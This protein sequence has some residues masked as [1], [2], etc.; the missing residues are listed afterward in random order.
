MIINYLADD[1]CL[2]FPASILF[3]FFFSFM[4]ATWQCVQLSMYLLAGTLFIW[5]PGSCLLSDSVSSQVSKISW[6]MGSFFSV[7]DRNP[8]IQLQGK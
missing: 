1:V 8:C 5:S 2:I 7:F 6:F 4:M 3:F